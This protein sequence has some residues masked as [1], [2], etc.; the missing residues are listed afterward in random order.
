MVKQ[1]VILGHSSIH[2][3]DQLKTVPNGVKLI[4]PTKCGS[5]LSKNGLLRVLYSKMQTANRF[6]KG[7]N[8]R[9]NILNFYGPNGY[10]FLSEA[11]KLNNRGI[12]RY[13]HDPGTIYINQVV[14]FAPSKFVKDKKPF[15]SGVYKLPVNIRSSNPN[16][17]RRS[18]WHTNR[19][20][21]LLS[22]ILE[23]IKP[24]KTKNEEN[25]VVYGHFCRSSNNVNEENFENK[26]GRKIEFKVNGKTY[27]LPKSDIGKLFTRIH[28]GPHPPKIRKAISARYTKHTEL[29]RHFK[30]A[31]AVGKK[32]Q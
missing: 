10:K 4:F 15:H 30:S 9:Q 31:G 28:R 18:V 19:G 5:S 20:K 12:K 22:N 1:Y 7:E 14:Q 2:K 24:N 23:R 21:Y 25:V 27:R 26:E 6:S 11:F 8:I 13:E 16:F 29:K 17:S 32:V 3:N